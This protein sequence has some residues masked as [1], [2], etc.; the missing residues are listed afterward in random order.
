MHAQ[1]PLNCFWSLHASDRFC[2]VPFSH[3]S[4]RAASPSASLY[5]PMHVDHRHLECTTPTASLPSCFFPRIDL[6]LPSHQT[7]LPFPGYNT[8]P[9]FF[10]HPARWLKTTILINYIGLPPY[11]LKQFTQSFFTGPAFLILL[12]EMTYSIVLHSALLRVYSPTECFP[13]DYNS[14]MNW[15]FHT[16]HYVHPL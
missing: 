15:P 7:C 11:Y 3:V 14:L 6:L 5:T 16:S 10:T 12:P 2:F 8:C 4:P 9:L 13:P 1:L